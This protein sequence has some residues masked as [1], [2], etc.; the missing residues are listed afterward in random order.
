MGQDTAGALVCPPRF[1]NQGKAAGLECAGGG[2][3]APPGFGIKAKRGQRPDGLN[4]KYA[5]PGF[6]IKAKPAS[7]L[8]VC[9]LSMPPPVL[10]S[11]QSEL[12]H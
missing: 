2:E 9:P 7:R 12:A 10:E 6:G 11:R 4:A 1:W 5:P 3:Y 8:S